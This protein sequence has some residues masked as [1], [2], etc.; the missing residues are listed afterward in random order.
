[1]S[2]LYLTDSLYLKTMKKIRNALDTD[3]KEVGGHDCTTIGFKNT[4]MNFGMC[5]DEYTTKDTA[6]FPNKFPE[7]KVMKYSGKG[8]KCPLDSRMVKDIDG[9]GCFYS[10]RFFQKGLRDKGMIKKL[11]DEEI[12]RVEKLL[13]PK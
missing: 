13:C 9:M 12:K 8:H 1:M 5:N 2:S 6:L 7:R 4:T 11:Y 10:C 3:N